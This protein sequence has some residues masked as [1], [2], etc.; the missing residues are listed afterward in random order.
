[1]QCLGKLKTPSSRAGGESK[2]TVKFNGLCMKGPVTH[3]K[4]DLRKLHRGNVIPTRQKKGETVA[5]HSGTWQG[6]SLYGGGGGSKKKKKIRANDLRVNSL[7]GNRE[8]NGAKN[9]NSLKKSNQ[10]ERAVFE[11]K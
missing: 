7:P 2:I 5:I 3:G 10:K 11:K 8:G 9:P 4:G 6:D 1:V